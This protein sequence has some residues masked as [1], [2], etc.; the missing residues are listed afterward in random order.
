MLARAAGIYNGEGGIYST[1]DGHLTLRVSQ[2]NCSHEP[3]GAPSLLVQFH[4]AIG[5][6]ALTGPR[7]KPP[8]NRPIWEVVAHRSEAIRAFDALWPWLSVA[9]RRQGNVAIDASR[10]RLAPRSIGP[11]VPVGGNFAFAAGVYSGEGGI[12]CYERPV[13]NITLKVAQSNSVH[14]PTG[15]PSLLT[16]FR[17]AVGCGV[18]Q[19]PYRPNAGRFER[20][21]YVASQD[22]A[23]DLYTAM[24]PWLTVA[25]RRQGTAALARWAR[26]ERAH[27]WGTETHFPC[28]HARSEGNAVTSGTNPHCRECHRLRSQERNRRMAATAKAWGLSWAEFHAIPLTERRARIAAEATTT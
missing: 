1:T 6:G 23:V 2:S 21:I 16:Q 4:E 27:V 3:E 9:K 13:S 15:E 11:T 7:L 12:Y 24:E 28:G 18:I 22:A 14:E 10:A 17:E 19:G 20:W 26:V 25:K 8:R 5:V